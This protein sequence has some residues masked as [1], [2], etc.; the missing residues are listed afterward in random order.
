VVEVGR[1]FSDGTSDCR[2]RVADG[3]HGDPGTEIDQLVAIDVN[4][5]RARS[6]F[7]EGCEAGTDAGGH[8]A[9]PSSGECS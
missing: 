5:D 8:R 3:A 6:S 9:H 7:D 4:E 2:V 1:L